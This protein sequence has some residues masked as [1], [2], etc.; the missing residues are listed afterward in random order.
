ME[1]IKT[2]QGVELDG[3]RLELKVS[4]RKDKDTA[5]NTRKETKNQKQPDQSAKLIVR[6]V[7]FQVFEFFERNYYFK[8]C[9][10]L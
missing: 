3:H 5:G 10:E 8:R 7:P 2:L 1:M 6:N 9:S 4:N